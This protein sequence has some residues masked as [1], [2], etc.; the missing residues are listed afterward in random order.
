MP[1]PMLRPHRPRRAQVLRPFDARS[2]HGCDALRRLRDG[3]WREHRYIGFCVLDA[4]EAVLV[5]D[6]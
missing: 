5:S 1:A 3:E 2:A 4:G 6:R